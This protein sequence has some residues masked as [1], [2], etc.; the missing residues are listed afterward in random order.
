MK[1]FI[2]KKWDL[3]LIGLALAATAGVFVCFYS[4]LISDTAPFIFTLSGGIPASHGDPRPLIL[5]IC[6]HVVLFATIALCC[7]CVYRGVCALRGR[8][9]FDEASFIPQHSG[10]LGKFR[11][12]AYLLTIAVLLCASTAYAAALNGTIGAQQR[13]FFNRVLPSIWDE[14]VGAQYVG[15]VRNLILYKSDHGAFPAQS[16]MVP[17]SVL[18]TKIKY[19]GPYNY[20]G[21]QYRCERG[22]MSLR[23]PNFG[24]HYGKLYERYGVPSAAKD[25]LAIATIKIRNSYIPPLS[26]GLEDQHTDP[27]NRP[28]I[29]ADEQSLT[30]TFNNVNCR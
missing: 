2:A 7:I 6:L 16:G 19:F 28:A 27:A 1:N 12:D 13:F 20:E 30:V 15:A 23:T 25:A 29:L 14:A 10:R 9:S 26:T 17:I 8:A 24:P 3:L 11:E 22:T 18:G 21:W 5:K 4:I